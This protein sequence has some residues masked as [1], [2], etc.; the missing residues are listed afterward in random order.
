MVNKKKI[1]IFFVILIIVVLIIFIILKIFNYK[2]T[3]FGNN[4]SDKTLEEV[5]QYILNISSYE[6]EIEVTVESNK[7]CN[8]YILNQ[9]FSSPNYSYQRVIEPKNIEG[10]TIK[11]DGNNL[12]ILNSNLNL[13]SIYE[14]YS[15]I[16]DNIIWLSDFIENYKKNNGVI[17]EENN[18]IIME[19]KCNENKYSVYE[20]LYIDREQN[21]IAKL[22]VEDENKKSKIYITY[23]K[24]D[25]GGLNK[26][27]VL[28]VKLEKVGSRD[29]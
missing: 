19:V 28:A 20:K 12:E 14:N 24:V 6:A 27:G 7:N 16:A 5:E 9:K 17:R 1:V 15:Y 13:N 23:N 22:V 8:K 11:Y 25:I 29:I 26:E 4:I 2:N 10:L 3:K 18:I 21:K